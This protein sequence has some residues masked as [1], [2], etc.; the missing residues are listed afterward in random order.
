MNKELSAKLC[1]PVPS[2]RTPFLPDGELDLAGIRAQVDYYIFSGAQA[3]MLTWGDSLLSVLT[4]NEVAEMTKAVVEQT[5]GRAAV[6]AADG[7]WA[8]PKAVAFAAYCRE[9]GADLLMLLPPDWAGSCSVDNLVT[10]F[11]KAGEHLPV[12]MVTAFF[13]QAG[14]FSA[15]PIPFMLET[16]RRLIDEVPSLI[17]FKDDVLGDFGRQLCLLTRDTRVKVV[18][19][20]LMRNHIAQVPYGVDG[21]LCFILM[22]SPAHEWQY[23]K[24]IQ[25]GNYPAA[26]EVLNSVETPFWD[27]VMRHSA[28]VGFN[29]VVHGLLE[30][31]GICGRHVRAPYATLSP[32]AMQALRTDVEAVM[33]NLPA[34]CDG[35]AQ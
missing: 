14:V 19:G 12:M 2:I 18:S 27:L 34:V 13:S 1:T 4:E 32:A 5:A 15:R 26:W 10:H 17:A 21:Y 16:A 29:A 33:K 11:R 22:L 23:W 31:R 20:G 24:A 3:L 9:I 25:E 30:I 6:I 28:G 7:G 35:G 8:T